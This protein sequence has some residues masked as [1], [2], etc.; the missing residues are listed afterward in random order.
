MRKWYHSF[1][2]CIF[3]KRAPYINKIDL[4]IINWFFFYFNPNKWKGGIEVYDDRV[5]L[6]H[7]VYTRCLIQLSEKEVEQF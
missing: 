5:G 6:D 1:V 3:A 2:I 4:Y 7:P